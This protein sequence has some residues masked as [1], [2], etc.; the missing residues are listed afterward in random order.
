MAKF[1]IRRSSPNDPISGILPTSA[2]AAGTVVAP[3]G[4]A[5]KIASKATA[6]YGYASDQ[7]SGINTF[8]LADG[9]SLAGFVTK[10]VRVGAGLSDTEIA[11]GLP[12]TYP[13]GEIATPFEPGKAAT[14]VEALDVEAESPDNVNAVVSSTGAI[15]ANTAAGTKLSF[16]DGKF[17]VAQ[18][19]DWAQYRLVTAGLTPDV[20]G[21]VRIFATRITGEYIGTPS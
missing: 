21:C 20:S 7:D 6:D 19:G 2:E 3:V 13:S 9:T 11:F 18:S 5:Y 10:E 14:V 12:T 17:R 8:A 1:Y 4:T 15:A 16:V